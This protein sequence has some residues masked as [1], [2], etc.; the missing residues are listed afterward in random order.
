MLLAAVLAAYFPALGGG[1]LW[2]DDAHVT[3]AALRPLHGLWRIWTEAGATQQYYPV[4]HTAFWVEH[5]LW[6]DSV[7]GY[8]LA[9]VAL[10]AAAAWLL[11]LILRSLSFPAALLAGLTFALHPV[12]V[13]SVAWI[14]E[15]KNTLSAVFYLSAA[16]AYLRFDGTRS[17]SRYWCAFALYA[18]AL[19]SKSVTATLPAALLVVFWW[20]RGRLEWRR[21]IAPLLPWFAVGAASGLF[22]AW[23]ERRLIGAEGA[24][25]SLSA[26][27]RVLLAG[28]AIAFYAGKLAWPG[29]LSFVYPRWELNPGEGSQYLCLAGVL[30]LLAALAAVARRCR[31]PLAGF[32]FF[33]GTLFPALGFF[34]VY[35]FIYSYVAD[36]F[37]YLA[38][39]GIIVPAA[40]GL[41]RVASGSP[42][43]A[44]GRAC[45]LLAVP[46][47]LGCL[48][49]RQCHIYADEDTLNRSTLASN[50]SAWR[51]HYNLAVSLGGR[52]GHL[53]E[54]ISEYQATLRIKPDY[55]AAHSNLGSAYLATPGRLTDAVA[56]Y[57]AALRINPGDAEA[58]NNL[59]I[60]LGRIPGR[61]PEAISH[62]R[63]ALRIRPGYDGALNDLGALLMRQPGALDEAIGDLEAAVRL[64]PGNA[65]YHYDLANALAAAPGRLGGAVAEYREAIR[66]SP[67]FA[68][69][70]GNLGEALFRTAGEYPEAISELEAATR[71]AP[72]N[73][74]AHVNLAN[75]LA[76][77]PGRIPSAVA[78]YTA[79]ARIDPGNAQ[80]HVALGV[81]LLRI[82][83]SQRDAVSEFETAVRLKPD[84]AL[85]HY[86][87]GEVLLRAPG[88]RDEAIGH[89]E[90]AL[91]IDPGFEPARRI[92]DQLKSAR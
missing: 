62:L 14:S 23:Y 4:L 61:L 83:G 20:R 59:G 22:S 46:A 40:W 32:L 85:A 52:P 8:H 89:I 57:E 29:D 38:S 44:P 41:G 24:D 78:E 45:L 88:R 74:S 91:E 49:W 26:L 31:G 6:G 68:E 30:A 51:A 79:A 47:V 7:L 17:V 25:F 21:D 53:P 84:Y 54:A 3:K 35:P 63:T 37:Q 56:E 76:R 34:N 69:A 15:Q 2:D 1:F 67:G 36:H 18:L 12:C 10:H 66:L 42:L 82:P 77:D 11:V 70:H 33:C 86:C 81:A 58:Q 55:W 9:N 5:R 90:R 65:E 87:L 92:L 64:S 73:P 13:E 43:G 71:L 19:L 48:T 16:L 80:T 72:Q 27:Q 39:I 75:A 50:P 60:A 28:R